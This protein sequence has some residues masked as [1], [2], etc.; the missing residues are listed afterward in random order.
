MPEKIVICKGYSCTH[1]HLENELSSTKSKMSR[2]SASKK[3]GIPK[4]IAAN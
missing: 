1:K 3:H 2:R 4:T